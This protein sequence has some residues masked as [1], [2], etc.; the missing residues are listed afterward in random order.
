MTYVEEGALGEERLEA[1]I[2]EGLRVD[3]RGRRLA[4]EGLRAHALAYVVVN[5]VLIGVWAVT[6]RRS[7]WPK[8]PVMGWGLGLAAHAWIIRT[9]NEKR[10]ILDGPAEV[11]APGRASGRERP[12]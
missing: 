7:F 6:D 1:L 12:T 8:W 10:R 11:H 9:V 4:E 3:E 5:A 2:A